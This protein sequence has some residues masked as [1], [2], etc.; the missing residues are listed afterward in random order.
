MIFGADIEDA[1]GNS[2]GG[3]DARSGVIR[4]EWVAAIGS[5]EGIHLAII[6]ADVDDAVVDDWGRPDDVTCS[7]FPKVIIRLRL[8][9][10]FCIEV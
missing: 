4:P 10:D 2:W 9:Y 6:G 5:V 3:I 8:G 1:V 7:C